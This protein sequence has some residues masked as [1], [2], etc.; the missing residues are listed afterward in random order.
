MGLTFEPRFV[1]GAAVFACF[2]LL[3]DFFSIPLS[4]RTAIG[5]VEHPD[6]DSGRGVG[7]RLGP[8]WRLFLLPCSW[9]GETRCG[10]ST[11]LGHNV[12]IVYLAGIVF[13]LR[14]RSRSCST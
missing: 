2:I 5:R 12:T 14:L 3:G 10:R 8:R 1:V 13:S 11:K 9:E 4:K 6:H 7:S